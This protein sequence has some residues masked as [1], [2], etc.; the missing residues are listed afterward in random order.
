MT[1]TG[2][3]KWNVNQE[4]E[5][6]VLD[7]VGNEYYFNDSTS[8]YFDFAKHDQPKVTFELRELPGYGLVAW[9]VKTLYFN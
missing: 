1:V 7:E 5:G 9:N 4:A 2:K 8:P 3:V 6:I